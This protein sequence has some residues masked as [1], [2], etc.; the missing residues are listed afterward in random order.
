MR[1]RAACTLPLL[2]GLTGCASR[3]TRRDIEVNAAL[4]GRRSTAP[5]EREPGAMAL[6]AAS[7]VRDQVHEAERGPTSALRIPISRIVMQALHS[8]ADDTF[9]RGADEVQ[10]SAP[11]RTT[12]LLRLQAV[13]VSY[14]QSTLWFVPIPIPYLGILPLGDDEFAVQLAFDASLVDAQ[15]RTQWTRNYDDGR[16]VWP[17]TMNEQHQAEAGLMRL[18]HEAAWR[19]AQRAVDDVRAEVEAERMRVRNL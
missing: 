8:A 1:R 12:A 5:T 13:R 14:H 16:Q 18:T 9:A 6:Q 11:A 15:G 4:F 2:A 3:P 19:L 7:A 17:H 10:A